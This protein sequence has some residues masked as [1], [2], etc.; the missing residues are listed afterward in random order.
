MGLSVNCPPPDWQTHVARWFKK[1]KNTVY[2]VVPI[3]KSNVCVC[4]TDGRCR[5]WEWRHMCTTWKWE[6]DPRGH[7]Y[8]DHLHF[9]ECPKVQWE[10][11]PKVVGT[12]PH[13]HSLPLS[14]TH[15][16]VV[17]EEVLQQLSQLEV[18]PQEALSKI[19]HEGDGLWGHKE[20]YPTGTLDSPKPVVIT[21][22][23]FYCSSLYCTNATRRAFSSCV[24]YTI[25]IS[26]LIRACHSV[27]SRTGETCTKLGCFDFP[28]LDVHMPPILTSS[29]SWC[30][31]RVWGPIS[32]PSLLGHHF[33]CEWLAWIGK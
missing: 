28:S 16:G 32:F 26:K 5:I 9:M 14:A 19:T 6:R 30:L 11:A 27:L 23:A 10:S 25:H 18:W 3:L 20:E 1:K 2:Y 22:H 15:Q 12:G 29:T 31:G 4:G 17:S 33:Q 8:E 7:Q 24:N 13:K 21:Q